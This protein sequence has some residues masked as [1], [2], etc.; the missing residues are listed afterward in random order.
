LP[1][2]YSNCNYVVPHKSNAKIDI[3]I[4]DS[5]EAAISTTRIQ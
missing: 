3:Y 1:V 5:Y 2:K 4:S